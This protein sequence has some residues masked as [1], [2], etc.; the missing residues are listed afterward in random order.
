MG[1]V[2]KMD[3]EAFYDNVG[4]V[5]STETSLLSLSKN[6]DALRLRISLDLID[7]Q[8]PPGLTSNK[9]ELR[10]QQLFKQKL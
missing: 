4:D 7:S 8:D 10:V 6:W 3:G 9:G 1:S 2:H 5:H